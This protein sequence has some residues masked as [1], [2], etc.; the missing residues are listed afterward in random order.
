MQVLA[1]IMTGGLSALVVLV[2]RNWA[3]IKAAIV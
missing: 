2:V 3:Q 1:A